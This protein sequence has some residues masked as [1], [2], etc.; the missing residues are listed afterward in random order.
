MEPLRCRPGSALLWTI[1]VIG[2]L[3]VTA[4]AAAPY[5]VQVNDVTRVNDAAQTLRD[6]AEGIDSF[7]LT[8][9]RGS[10][11]FTTP[12]QLSQLTAT[13][14]NGQTAGCTAQNYNATAVG[15]W[16]TG[17][18][19]TAF[20]MPSNG[21]WTPIGRVNNRPSK[22]SSRQAVARTANSDP[23]YVQIPNVDI[24]DARMLDLAID[25]AL[26]ADSDTLLYSAP[27]PDSTVLVSYHVVL[28]HSPAC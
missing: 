27:A 10:A 4:A 8:A 11:S 15:N 22:D 12:N 19:Y 25:G 17:A 20:W 18:P 5:L 1:A 21:L 2:C 13:I 14:V 9:K 6:I 7:N 16:A 24:K 23:Y 28:A 26:D 3:A